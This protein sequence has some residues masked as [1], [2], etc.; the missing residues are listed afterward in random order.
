MPFAGEALVDAVYS[1]S[2]GG[3]TESGA[4]LWQGSEHAY[5]AGVPDGPGPDPFAGGVTDDAVR[6]FVTKPPAG[7]WCGV[8][9]YGKESFRW[10]RTVTAEEARQG[11]RAQTGTDVG[12]VRDLRPLERGAS[13]RVLRLEVVG[14]S[15]TLALSP[16]LAIRKALGGLKSSLFVVDPA[17]GGFRFRGA[18]FGHGV[19]LCQNGAI[20]MADAGRAYRD[21]LR[22]YYRGSEVVRIY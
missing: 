18:G 15:R 1:A 19:G 3:H 4:A 10:E 17:P 16:E 12:A 6:A 21:I 13:G 8:S 11:V 2:C 22:H 7:L 9:R 14:A 5:L 20:G